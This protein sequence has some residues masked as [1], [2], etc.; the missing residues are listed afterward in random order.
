MTHFE[1]DNNPQDRIQSIQ[2]VCA[3]CVLGNLSKHVPIK[4]FERI[5]EDVIEENLCKE[6]RY[7][8]SVAMDLDLIEYSDS[9]YT[10]FNITIS[11]L[12]ALKFLSRMKQDED[13]AEKWGKKIKMEMEK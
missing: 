12:T 13:E 2:Y 10:K 3:A 7:F 1:Y 11:K 6:I 8:S 4:K 9:S 5:L